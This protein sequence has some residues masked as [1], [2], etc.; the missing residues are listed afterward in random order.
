MSFSTVNTLQ[1]LETYKNTISTKAFNINEPYNLIQAQKGI[2]FL[3]QLVGGSPSTDIQFQNQQQLMYFINYS[4]YITNITKLPSVDS[5]E[6]ELKTHIMEFRKLSRATLGDIKEGQPENRIMF[7]SDL[8]K[9]YAEW[10]GIEAHIVVPQ[11]YV[12]EAV[13]NLKPYYKIAQAQTGK[14]QAVLKAFLDKLANPQGLFDEAKSKNNLEV[15]S[16]LG[17]FRQ[18][19]PDK[20]KFIDN[21]YFI[22]SNIDLQ[23]EEYFTLRNL[24]YWINYPIQDKYKITI[25]TLDKAVQDIIRKNKYQ[26][27]VSEAQA[28]QAEEI[29]KKEDAEKKQQDAKN[30]PPEEEPVDVL[31]IIRSEI[32]D[33]DSKS[34]NYESIVNELPGLAQPPTVEGLSLLEKQGND[35]VQLNQ[36]IL[37]QVNAINP[38]I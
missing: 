11:N 27:M 18:R 37:N 38:K 16:F 2:E 17:K 12:D 13:A 24:W 19:H 9:Q 8:V 4:E 26:K 30:R 25:P 33:L 23:N 14:T 34:Q 15:Q 35:A 5:S 6:E 10:Q 32:G 7:Y 21:I 29:K 31:D 20:I 3:S 28:A 36:K 22:F 1:L